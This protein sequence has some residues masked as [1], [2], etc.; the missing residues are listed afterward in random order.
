MEASVIVF[1]SEPPTIEIKGEI[2]HVRDRSG[3]VS[4]DRAMSIHSFVGYLERGRLALAQWERDK[5]KVLPIA[6]SYD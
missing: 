4:I 3:D 6:G 1:V 2:V 5:A